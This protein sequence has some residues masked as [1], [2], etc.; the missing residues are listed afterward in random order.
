MIVNVRKNPS[1]HTLKRFLF[2]VL[3]VFG[4]ADILWHLPLF[5]LNSRFCTSMYIFSVKFFNTSFKM[6]FEIALVNWITKIFS[7]T[8]PLEIVYEK[9][10]LIFGRVISCLT[11]NTSKKFLSTQLWSVQHCEGIK[12]ICWIWTQGIAKSYAILRFTK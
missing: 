8:I 6:C 3:Q 10:S 9:L 5:I 2:M 11:S 7:L 4:E 12:T 1:I